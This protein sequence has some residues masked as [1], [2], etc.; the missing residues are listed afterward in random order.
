MS[1]IQL[2]AKIQQ[3][4]S[5][6]WQGTQTGENKKTLEKTFFFKELRIGHI[7]QQFRLGFEVQQSQIQHF[8]G[9]NKT[10]LPHI[11]TYE[12]ML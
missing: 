7:P 5:W 11:F 4:K 3:A 10:K 1:S 12:N 9:S 2:Y 8:L 6:Q